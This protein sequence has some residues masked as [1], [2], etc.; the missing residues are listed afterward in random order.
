[1][2]IEPADRCDGAWVDHASWLIRWRSAANVAA[3]A[4]TR[5]AAVLHG[6]WLLVAVTLLPGV[7]ARVPT[8]SL[9]A[10]LVVAVVRLVNAAVLRAWWRSD[11]VNLLIYGATAGVIIGAGVLPGVA[12][13]FGLSLAKLLHTFSRLA[14]HAGVQQVQLLLDHEARR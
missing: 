10:V 6:A 11:R 3:G 13:G 9:A 8:T 2:P 1:M 5:L 7:L 14:V 4:R 12:V